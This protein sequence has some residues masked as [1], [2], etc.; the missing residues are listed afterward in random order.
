MKIGIVKSNV[1]A[2]GFIF[3]LSI[4]FIPI[5]ISCSGLDPSDGFETIL[6]VNL[7]DDFE[8]GQ[9]NDSRWFPNN[10][11]WK[12]RHPSIFANENSFIKNG[13]LNIVLTENY[14]KEQLNQGYK[15]KTGSIVSKHKIKYG[16][17]EIRAKAM[18]SSGSSAFWLYDDNP[19]SWTEIDVFEIGGVESNIVNTNAHA[20]RIKGKLLGMDVN[21][22]HAEYKAKKPLS[23][24]FHIYRLEWTPRLIKWFVDDVEVNRIKNEFWHYPL[25]IVFDSEVFSKWLGLPAVDE[26]RGAYQVDYLKVSKY[27]D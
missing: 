7:S 17:F 18:N 8:N 27:H 24:D 21:A 20:F 15:Y 14:N 13:A 5:V 22:Y 2:R 26:T 19:D 16:I 3:L 9:I 4:I 23:Q 11:K 12:G 10:P 1:S 6:D 25:A